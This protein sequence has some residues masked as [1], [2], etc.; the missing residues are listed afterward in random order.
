MKKVLKPIFYTLASF[1]VGGFISMSPAMAGYEKVSYQPEKIFQDHKLALNYDVYAGGFKALNASLKMDL[2]K[3]AY[4]MALDAKTEGFIGGMFPWK[5]SFN[6]AG[7][8]DDKGTLIPTLHT[9]RSN[10]K[11]KLSITEMTYAPDGTVLKATTNDQGKITSNKN[12][13]ENLSKH[14]VD[15]LTGTLAMLQSAN[16]QGK[17]EGSFPVFDGKRRFNITL[18]DDGTEVLPK[19]RYSTFQ[20]EAMRCILKVEPVAGFKEK[21]KKRGWMAVQNHTEERH[22]LPTLWLAPMAEGG[23][24]VPVRMEIA[25]AYGTVV[26]HLSNGTMN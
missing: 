8:T 23:Q 15:L 12:I 17:C 26:A 24:I 3:Q 14:A 18:K 20:G 13:D 2:D 22:K 11:E 5:G 21:D 7:H 4:D 10:W 19:S 1:V 25:S 6:T 9:K 16:S